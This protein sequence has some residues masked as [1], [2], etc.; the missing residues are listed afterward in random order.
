MNILLIFFALP[1]AII[2]LSIVFQKILNCPILVGGTVFAVF[3]IVAFALAD[4][5]TFLIAGIVYAII[6]FI[7]A[8]LTC[9]ISRTGIFNN[10][11]TNVNQNLVD[12]ITTSL[13][14][15]GCCN[16]GGC[17]CGNSGSGISTVALLSDGNNTSGCCNRDNECE[18]NYRQ[19]NVY[20]NKYRK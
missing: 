17:G 16:N 14:D 1:V 18:R 3:L 2:I 9:I 5:V 11:C 13:I 8:Y 20:R 10:C 4:T 6:A 15:S 19:Y 12:A 7:T